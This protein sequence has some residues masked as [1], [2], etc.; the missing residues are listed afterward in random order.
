MKHTKAAVVGSIAA[1]GL[2]IALTSAAVRSAEPGTAFAL[3][4]TVMID[5]GNDTC[6]TSNHVVVDANETFRVCYTLTNTGS[7]AL[8]MHGAWDS[9]FGWVLGPGDATVVEPGDS[10]SVTATGS[11]MVSMFHEVT[12]SATG[13]ESGDE[14]ERTDWVYVTIDGFAIQLDMTMMVDDGQETC[15]T[16]TSLAVAAGTPVRFCY[17]MTNTTEEALDQHFL[18]DEHLGIL[19]TFEGPSLDPGESLVH[20]E[21]AVADAGGT[22]TSYWEAYGEQGDNYHAIDSVSIDIID[23]NDATTT[24]PPDPCV[25]TTAPDVPTT[26]TPT[27]T[28]TLPD[29]TTTSTTTSTTSTTS[30]TTTSTTTTSTTSP[31]LV[32]LTTTTTPLEPEGFAAA[33]GAHRGLVE[34]CPGTTPGGELPPTR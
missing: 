11:N 24:A 22:R 4:T 5:D 32:L 1:L 27:P 23:P 16:E 3:E 18:L 30:T 25:T 33:G 17:T 14:V 20:T 13:V 10:L 15:G 21:V 6:A 12:W 34:P 9:R 2:S 29:T 31:V 7:E 8:S 19:L 28:T 26:T